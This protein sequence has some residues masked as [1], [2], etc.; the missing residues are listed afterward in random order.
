M[1][2]DM[3]CQFESL[4]MYYKWQVTCSL[5][6]QVYGPEKFHIESCSD[7][8]E[9]CQHLQDLTY[10]LTIFNNLRIIFCKCCI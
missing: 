1:D 4:N 7:E 8:G 6:Q 3:Y 9:L 10:D 5:D 2:N